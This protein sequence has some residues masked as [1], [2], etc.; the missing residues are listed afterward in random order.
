M[1]CQREISRELLEKKT[2]S[3]I[4]AIIDGRTGISGFPLVGRSRIDAPEIDGRVFIDQ[5]G[6]AA[7]SLVKVRITAS[8]DH[9]LFGAITV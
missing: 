9:D 6:Y 7:G 8:D 1:T 5:A 2:G 4:D 3:I